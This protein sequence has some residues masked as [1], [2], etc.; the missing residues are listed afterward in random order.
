MGQF[1]DIML[2]GGGSDLAGSLVNSVF[3]IGAAKR[4]RKFQREMADYAYTKDLEMWQR[5]N[6]YNAP[7]A[8]MERLKEAGLNPNMVYGSGSAVG[9]TSTQTPKYQK[10]DTPTAAFQ[11][12]MMANVLNQYQDLRIKKQEESS[13]RQDVIG[14]SIHNHFLAKLLGLKVSKG[15][16]DWVKDQLI[17]GVDNL[18]PDAM[19]I[20]YDTGSAE[21]KKESKVPFLE[22]YQSDV[23]GQQWQNVLKSLDYQLRKS[24]GTTGSNLINTIIRLFLMR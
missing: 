14:K 16:T 5:A 1:S 3:N 18:N 23:A 13:K 4:Q 21:W 17:L 6:E 20:D 7:A 9:N 10:Y 8:Q 22:R 15:V 24:G 12:P 19:K 2:Q 11:L